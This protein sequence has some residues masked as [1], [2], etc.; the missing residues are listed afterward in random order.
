MKNIIK[1]SKQGWKTHSYKLVGFRISSVSYIM[2]DWKTV[3]TIG[4]LQKN[5]KPFSQYFENTFIHLHQIFSRWWLTNFLRLWL[6]IWIMSTVY[7]SFLISNDENIQKNDFTFV[8]MNFLSP[9]QDNEHTFPKISQKLWERLVSLFL[10]TWRIF[11]VIQAND[12][13]SSSLWT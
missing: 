5:Q 10:Q 7:I 9:P 11:Y 6:H 3:N 4:S 1:Y 12:L 13:L 8:L 2:M